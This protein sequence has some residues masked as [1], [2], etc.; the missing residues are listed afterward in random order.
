MGIPGGFVNEM[1]PEH[2]NPG[3]YGLR[4]LCRI[5]TS[6]KEI[7]ISN[8][9]EDYEYFRGVTNYIAVSKKAQPT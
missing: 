5:D 9:Y 6:G 8:Y 4:R 7:P 3:G 2:E 1:W